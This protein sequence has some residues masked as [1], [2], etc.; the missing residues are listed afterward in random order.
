MGS[1]F[2]KKTKPGY[3]KHIDAK[4][5]ELATPDLFT[6]APENGARCAVATVSSG[7]NLSQGDAVIVETN[8]SD[9]LARRGNTIIAKFKNPPVDVFSAVNAGGGLAKGTIKQ[10]NTLSKTVEISIC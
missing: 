10:V 9:L 6:K 5:A 3:N 4:R 2:L 1:E 7:A 8:G